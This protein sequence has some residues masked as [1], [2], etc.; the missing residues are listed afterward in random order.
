MEEIQR[1]YNSLV[2]GVDTAEDIVL[3]MNDLL[4]VFLL[5]VKK[6]FELK[7]AQ[8]KRGFI[9][10]SIKSITNTFITTLMKI[11]AE[12]EVKTIENE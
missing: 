3:K 8:S 11:V 4:T 9:I 7:Q 5:L 2:E 12:E 6:A 10:D 1:L